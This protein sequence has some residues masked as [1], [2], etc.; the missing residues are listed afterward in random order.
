MRRRSRRKAVVSSGITCDLEMRMNDDV[1]SGPIESLKAGNDGS[2][3]L[4]Q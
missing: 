2:V 3:A 4:I 1:R